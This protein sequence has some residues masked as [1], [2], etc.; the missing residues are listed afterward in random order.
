VIA[1]AVAAHLLWLL[2]LYLVV[3]TLG[4]IVYPELCARWPKLRNAVGRRTSRDDAT[5]IG[6]WIRAL[7]GEGSH[8]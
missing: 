5:A 3:T 2:P 4:L 7:M 1:F 8:V 6:G